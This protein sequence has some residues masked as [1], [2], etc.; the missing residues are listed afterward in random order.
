MNKMN[1]YKTVIEIIDGVEKEFVMIEASNKSIIWENG[2]KRRKRQLTGNRSKK[3]LNAKELKKLKKETEGK[4]KK[5]LIFKILL[6]PRSWWINI[7]TIK[8]KKLKKTYEKILRKL[9]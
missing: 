8:S 9:T 1:V 6:N 4:K 5:K 7:I 2:S 3:I